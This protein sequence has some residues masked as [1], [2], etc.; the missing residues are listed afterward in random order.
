MT[1]E[2]RT[3]NTS[4]Y[5]ISPRTFLRAFLLFLFSLT[6]IEGVAPL[7]ERQQQQNPIVMESSSI[8]V[9]LIGR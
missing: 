2:R 3:S 5:Q 4:E 1:L 9:T 6:F 7:F 8:Y